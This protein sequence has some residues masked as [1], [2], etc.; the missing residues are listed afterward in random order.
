MRYLIIKL[1]FYKVK[2][3]KYS[4]NATFGLQ[5]QKRS[6]RNNALIFAVIFYPHL[7]GPFYSILAFYNDR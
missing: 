4:N 5:F 7:N 6:V 2:Y 1:Y 3:N